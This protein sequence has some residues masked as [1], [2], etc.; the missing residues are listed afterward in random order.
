MKGKLLSFPP[1]LGHVIIIIFQRMIWLPKLPGRWRDRHIYFMLSSTPS[2]LPTDSTLPA[3]EFLFPGL[4]L[5]NE[6]SLSH[7]N[8]PLRQAWPSFAQDCEG[9]V[10][11]ETSRFMKLLEDTLSAGVAKLVGS[12]SGSLAHQLKNLL[13]DGNRQSPDT[14]VWVHGASCV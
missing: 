14:T 10:Q 2:Y 1:D 9:M 6:P 3:S 11:S 4:R 7:S 12:A 8:G 5:E 13:L